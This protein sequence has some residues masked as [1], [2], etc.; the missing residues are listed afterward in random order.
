MI[1]HPEDNNP[2][3]TRNPAPRSL[4]SISILSF[5]AR[6]RWETVS[7][8]LDKYAG[9]VDIIM[10]Q[11]PAWRGVHTQPSTTNRM[12]D[13]AFGPPTH[14][15]WKC[16]TESFDNRDESKPGPRALTYINKRLDIF[17]PQLHTDILKHRDLS[18]VT[19]HLKHPRDST[20]HEFNILN[21]YN[22]GHTHDTLHKLEQVSDILPNIS[23]CAG[24][25]NI[26]DREWDEGAISHYALT[27]PYMRLKDVMNK[28]E[29][30][31]VFP[32]NGGEATHIP[33]QPEQRASFIDLVFTSAGMRNQ[34]EF[35]YRIKVDEAERWGSDHRM[36]K[37][38][39]PFLEGEPEV[40]PKRKIEAW[41]EEEDGYVSFF[42]FFFFFQWQHIF[43]GP[44]HGYI[45]TT[46]I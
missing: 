28:L 22:D 37:M 12:G 7:T 34:Q 46:N 38:E 15:S 44:L 25:F 30:E 4:S 18:L 8:V 1:E 36:L 39:V 31:Y 16:Y 45:H 13:V 27:S 5:N 26:Q 10:F 6:K 9:Y 42:F 24:D 40:E 29:L 43:A 3:R 19:L 11:E 2:S 33:D 23:I 14:P 35:R 21:V 32:S 20:P 17:R 41:S